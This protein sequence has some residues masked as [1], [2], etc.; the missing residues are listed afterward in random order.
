MT[1]TNNTTNLTSGWVAIPEAEQRMINI[2]VAIPESC[3]PILHEALER[4]A[5]AEAQLAAAR[6]AVR[7]MAE[8]ASL[9]TSEE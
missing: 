4:I 5:Q 9:E 7:A 3:G 8:M 2:T 6:E 1:N